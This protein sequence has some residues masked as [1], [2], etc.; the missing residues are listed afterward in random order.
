M[1]E[2][3][4]ANKLFQSKE[5]LNF[6]WLSGDKVIKLFL[7]LFIGLWVARYLEP[8]NFGILTFWLTLLGFFEV[9]ASFGMQ[10]V[11]VKQVVEAKNKD[12]I[13][14][15]AIILRTILSIIAGLLFLI[16]AIFFENIDVGGFQLF[17][18]LILFFRF[19]E[20]LKFFFE[21]QVKSKYT[22]W[23]ESIA[24]TLSGLMKV[25]LILLTESLELFFIVSV[26][27]TVFIFLL[28]VYFA[29]KNFAEIRFLDFSKFKLD[30]VKKLFKDSFP[31]FLASL[32][33]TLYMKIDQIMVG[34]FLQPIDL[35]HYAVAV[36]ITEVWY[37]VPL[38]IISS[39]FP[40]LIENFPKKNQFDGLLSNLFFSLF[41]ISM[42]A[43]ILT[44]L[45]SKNII[46]ILFGDPYLPS[47][48][49]LNLYIFS[50][51]LVGFNTLSDRWYQLHNLSYLIFYKSLF[52]AIANIILNYF[53]IQYLGP[54]G[55]ALSTIISLFLLVYV[56]DLLFKDTRSLILVK[57]TSII[58]T[59]GVRKNIR[60]IIEFLWGFLPD[61]LKNSIM[62]GRDCLEYQ[63]NENS[64]N[65]ND[66]KK[67]FALNLRGIYAQC[68]SRNIIQK[69]STKNINLKIKDN[70]NRI[71]VCSDAL[72]RFCKYKLSEIKTQFTLFTGDSDLG[73]SAN[74]LDE[75]DI[76]R[77]LMNPYLER[78]YA[79]NLN[80]PHPKLVNLPIGMDYHTD[81]YLLNYQPL[82]QEK[83]V[84]DIL[85]KSKSIYERE[86][87]AYCNWHFEMDRG[88]RKECYD[89]TSKSLCWY[90]TKRV[91]RKE[92]W[93]N[94]ANLAFCL[95]PEGVGF[96]CHRTYEAIFLGAIP[97]VKRNC[98]SKIF[99]TLPVI[100]VENYH[101]VTYE[102][103]MSELDRISKDK[104]DFSQLVMKKY[105]QNNDLDLENIS[106][107]EF[108]KI[109]LAS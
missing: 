72:P 88:D 43:S 107:E 91:S 42:I 81:Y 55:A 74:D 85:R 21:S 29:K 87:L 33:V 70:L 83:T 62:N 18:I 19:S 92:A 5:I 97:I 15:S 67:C 105:T 2:L 24:L 44:V 26:L 80:Y 32:T 46:G 109:F 68:D 69:S 8:S 106:F 73:I 17:L 90:E 65:N 79:Q 86:H 20:I 57:L 51:V 56:F 49:L 6:A 25:V 13:L 89:Q 16:T 30:P 108:Q 60:S 12:Q 94:Q 39:Y 98:L 84:K 53:L 23:S 47:A 64:R 76:K 100:I 3:K 101:D 7:G 28:M 31:F 37:F 99:D 82:E 61:R 96:D 103:L 34:I 45:L 4:P 10:N 27:E 38:A 104:F 71:Y 59:K 102:L 58:A 95:S 93:E 35:G 75:K 14:L 52:G 78:W 40:S 1:Q 63:L 66:F 36:K 54:I 11:I 9:F 48:A 77:I 50:G 22:A 41:W